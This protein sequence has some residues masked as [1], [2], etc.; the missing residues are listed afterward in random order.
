MCGK[1]VLV[2]EIK[3]DNT[4]SSGIIL[5]GND[6][7]KLGKVINVGPDVK[8]ITEGDKIVLIWGKGHALRMPGQQYAMINEDD[9]LAIIS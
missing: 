8:N 1:Y 6:N 3:Q 2:V 7:T 9:V 4:T 5:E